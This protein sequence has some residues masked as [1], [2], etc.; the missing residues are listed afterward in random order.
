M[1][2]G[3]KLE[4][5]DLLNEEREGPQHLTDS[6]LR[7]T[8]TRTHST[9]SFLVK[10]KRSSAR[11]RG[12]GHIWDLRLKDASGAL[13]YKEPLRDHIFQIDAEGNLSLTPFEKFKASDLQHVSD[14]R[15]GTLRDVVALLKEPEAGETAKE[16]TAEVTQPIASC[17]GIA[18]PIY[19]ANEKNR[20]DVFA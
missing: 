15:S 16:V 7:A 1:S 3:S 10:E 14:L 12:D 19:P 8:S 6:L 9:D 18:E 4:A 5:L 11:K 17:V 2:K 20:G 13:I